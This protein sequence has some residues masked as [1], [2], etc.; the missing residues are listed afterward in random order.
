M[1]EYTPS[2]K[3]KQQT[4]KRQRQNV[5]SVGHGETTFGTKEKRSVVTKRKKK[6]KKMV[7]TGELEQKSHVGE[8]AKK[9]DT[10]QPRKTHTRSNKPA[11]GKGVSKPLFPYD[12]VERDHC[13]SPRVAYQQI[14]PLLRSYASSIGKMAKELKIY[15][16]YYCNGAVKKHLRFLGYQDVYNE[17]EDFYNK[18][19]TDTVPAFDVMITNPPYSGDHMEKLLKFC[20]GYCAK[21]KKPFFLLLPNYVYTKEY[22]SDVFTEQPDSGTNSPFFLVPMRRRYYYSPPLWV[23]AESGSTSL[24]KLKTETSPYTTFWYC[25]GGTVTKTKFLI[26]SWFRLKLPSQKKPCYQSRQQLLDQEVALCKNK[27]DLPHEVRGEL[28]RIKSNKRPNPRARKR[29]NALKKKRR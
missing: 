19:E 9:K 24:K 7:G 25:S 8:R 27:F 21:K 23:D 11:E 28:D 17:C 18:I 12:A 14:E 13:E 3:K 22:Y 20:A 1:F 15:D 29:M 2:S 6:R 5:R 16:P 26:C 4:K 10:I